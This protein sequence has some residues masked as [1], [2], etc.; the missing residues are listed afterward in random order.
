MAFKCLKIVGLNLSA[1]GV[2]AIQ[3]KL[4]T[5]EALTLFTLIALAV[6]LLCFVCWNMAELHCRN[7]DPS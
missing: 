1:V 4:P 5:V 6:L 7:S 3:L 2:E